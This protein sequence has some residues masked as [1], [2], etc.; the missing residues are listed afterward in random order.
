FSGQLI[1]HSSIVC[2]P[3]GEIYTEIYL[4]APVPENEISLYRSGT[5]VLSNLSQLDSLQKSPWTST[6]F[7]GLMDVPFLNLTPGTR[8]GLIHDDRFSQWIQA[9]IPLEEQLNAIITEQQQQQDVESNRHI[10]KSV[11]KAI[12]EALFILPGEEYDWFEVYSKGKGPRQEKSAEVM[13]YAIEDINYRQN[14][15]LLNTEENSKGKQKQFF[16]YAGSLHRVQIS[17]ASCTLAVSQSRN[18]RAICR[19]K[20]GR[21]VDDGLTFSWSIF[22][23]NGQLSNTTEEI[24]EFKANDIPEICQINLTVKQYQDKEFIAQAIITVTDEILPEVKTQG[25]LKK[26]LPGYTLKKSPGELWRSTFDTEKNIVT[27]N[28]S[29]RDFIYAS[30]QKNR[31]VRYICRLYIKELVLANF[32]ELKGEELLERMIEVSL[33]AEESLR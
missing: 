27:I 13:P 18:L 4:N 29:H 7:Q 9:L 5:R 14:L 12:R 16:E 10:L 21:S 20:R 23:G 11:Q 15:D 33:Y 24:V 31:K 28:N 25:A 6:Y 32:I 19:D 1:Q 3:F 26:G 17:P 2:E 30:K 22:E 8:D